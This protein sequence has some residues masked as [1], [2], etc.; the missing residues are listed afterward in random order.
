VF[1]ILDE[2]A[3]ALRVHAL[4]RHA[5]GAI[6]GV[7]GAENSSEGVMSR[8]HETLQGKSLRHRS[9]FWSWETE[10]CHIAGGEAGGIDSS[11]HATRRRHVTVWLEGHELLHS[12]RVLLLARPAAVLVPATHPHAVFTLTGVHVLRGFGVRGVG[13][14]RS[15]TNFDDALAHA[16]EAVARL[17]APHELGSIE[18]L[19]HCVK[20]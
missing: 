18:A 7:C 4:F 12:V 17:A 13:G 10:L 11:A 2:F 16:A 9:F 6:V 3:H 19:P 8:A 1:V 14:A 20:G 15:R 5:L